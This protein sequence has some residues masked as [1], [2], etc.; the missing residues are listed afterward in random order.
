MVNSAPCKNQKAYDTQVKRAKEIVDKLGLNIV[1]C[2]DCGAVI[3]QDLKLKKDV[4]FCYQ[5]GYYSDPCDFPD[6]FYSYE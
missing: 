4:V 1:T 2:G 3:I 5:C 6:L